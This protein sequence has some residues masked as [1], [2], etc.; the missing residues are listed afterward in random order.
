MKKRILISSI[1]LLA[2]VSCSSPKFFKEINSTYNTEEGS[3][4]SSFDP[5]K[6]VLNKLEK[7]LKNTDHIIYYF[8]P[9]NDWNSNVFS[10]ALFDMDSKLY[11]Y[12]ENTKNNPR[13]VKISRVFGFPNDNYYKFV[14]DK[15]ME[16][17]IEY[18]KK[19]G[20]S[21]IS[22]VRTTQTIYDIDLI[23]SKVKKE[24]FKNFL[25][26]NGKPINDSR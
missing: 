18:L 20:K 4:R 13:K 23:G 5:H 1:L 25:F 24:T 17:E 26:L 11:F 8:S 12:F 15:Y 22:G 9:S 2:F 16:G 21:N 3:K 19:L 14:I 10:G 7:E 6:L